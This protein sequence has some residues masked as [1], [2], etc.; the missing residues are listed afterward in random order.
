MADAADFVRLKFADLLKDPD[1]FE[2]SLAPLPDKSIAV[3]L[4]T[5]RGKGVREMGVDDVSAMLGNFITALGG[6]LMP[7]APPMNFEAFE[8][9]KREEL[10]EIDK[11]LDELKKR[12]RRVAVE[13][14][15]MRRACA[16]LAAIDGP[17]AARRQVLSAPK[18]LPH[19]LSPGTLGELRQALEKSGRPMRAA[20][21]A[22]ATHR[23]LPAVNGALGDGVPVSVIRRISRGLYGLA[24]AS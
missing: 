15:I 20:E 12:K 21:L 6:D 9:A 19:R 5:G 1:C 24:E 17:R 7:N 22:A 10:E 14:K 16:Q 8:Q 23:S 11:Q 18:G 3:Q 2:L 13:L 4:R